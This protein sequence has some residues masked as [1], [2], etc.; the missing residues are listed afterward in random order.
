M[1]G[2]YGRVEF[3]AAPPPLINYQPV[4]VRRAAGAEPGANVYLYVPKGERLHWAQHCAR[5][6]ACH[7]AVFFVDGRRW[8]A[9]L[10]RH[11]ERGTTRSS[12]QALASSEDAET[13]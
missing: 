4:Q 5:Y 10:G 8:A 2:V 1:P 12:H 11:G 9:E 13:R 7:Q 6:H 3:N